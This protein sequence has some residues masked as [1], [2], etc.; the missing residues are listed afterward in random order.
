[1]DQREL[2]WWE[3]GENCIMRIFITYSLCQIYLEWSCQGGWE[4]RDMW[5]EWGKARRKQTTRKAQM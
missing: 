5:H 3:V 1:L 4:G 2:K